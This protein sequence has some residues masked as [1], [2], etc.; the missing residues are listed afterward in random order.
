VSREKIR[1]SSTRRSQSL[2]GTMPEP[3]PPD[4]TSVPEDDPWASPAAAAPK[5]R[6]E[7]CI[8]PPKSAAGR[9]F[10]YLYLLRFSLLLWL[11]LPAFVVLDWKNVLTTATR[12]ILT[13]ES[14][15]GWIWAGFFV[16][17]TGWIALLSARITCAYGEERFNLEPPNWMKVGTNMTWRTFLL[18]QAPGLVMLGYLWRLSVT[19]GERTGAAAALS[20]LSLLGGALIALAL[21]ALLTAFSYWSYQTDETLVKQ[22]RMTKVR[23]KPTGPDGLANTAFFAPVVTPAL[24]KALENAPSPALSRGFNDLFQRLGRGAGPGFHK[25][26]CD[27]D[28]PLNSGHMIALILFFYLAFLYY[29]FSFY[30]AP[31]PLDGMRFWL[32]VPVFGGLV[33]WF[34]KALPY[35]K[36]VAAQ[37]PRRVA[38]YLLGVAVVLLPVWLL[39]GYSIAL[40]WRQKPNTHFPV[41]ASIYILLF[42][43]TSGL[44][45]LAFL[46]DRYRVPVLTSAILAL[47]PIH[48]VA[49]M[50]GLRD[51]P[52]GEAQHIVQ[53][54]SPRGGAPASLMYPKEVLQRYRDTHPGN[55]PIVIVT[56]T[57]GGIHAAA[58][59]A[60]LLGELEKEF[61][62][63]NTAIPFHDSILLL[64]T[65]SGGSVGASEWIQA[66]PHYN[67]EGET[68]T[69]SG[70]ANFTETSGTPAQT[71]AQR[72]TECSSLEAIAWGLIYP[73]IVHVF[74][75]FRISD[76]IEGLDR[77]WALQRA[78]ERNE[79]AGCVSRED[80]GK[81]GAPVKPVDVFG[82][83]LGDFARTLGSGPA[84]VPA[85]SLN[86]TVA[87]TGDRF[88]LADYRLPVPTTKHSELLPASSFLDVFDHADTPAP[89]LA[90]LPLSAA[91]RLSA[92]FPFVSSMARVPRNVAQTPYHF[93]DGGYFDNDGTGTV[94]EFLRE[95]YLPKPED[96]SADE[97]GPFD[98]SQTTSGTPPPHAGSGS[99]PSV[100]D[101]IL[102]IEI[103]D[104]DDPLS[105]NPPDSLSNQ[106][107]PH[108]VWGP[109]EQLG[110][111]VQT[112]YHAGHESV[113][114]RNR[115]ELCVLESALAGTAQRISIEHYVFA[116]S[117][118]RK[119]VDQPLNWH[120]TSKD[121]DEIRQNIL[122]ESTV[123]LEERIAKRFKGTDP[124]PGF[125]E[126]ADSQ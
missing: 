73:D 75:P 83:T 25:D 49:G 92:S 22:H 77:S 63:Q 111:P 80:A 21:W 38:M 96:R 102:L 64:S 3:M 95:A 97:S 101:R 9:F 5:P 125:C 33:L 8:A 19:D 106:K 114:R 105:D 13:I 50:K 44:A 117:N 109:A 85:F 113:T 120:L 76:G 122:A 71:A 88:L 27:P 37:G 16:T 7:D 53:T 42:A 98:K 4:A 41:I 54:L 123:K 118:K 99:P 70:F 36:S 15:W 121:K 29:V 66:Y 60:Q 10:G 126:I 40:A 62:L 89:Q 43:L 90:D 69:S 107:A 79:P 56:A 124:A 11:S 81:A 17:L 61:A 72:I 39:V 45:G 74:I 78:I 86:T 47:I 82:A 2:E 59:T 52:F 28:S 31:V 6:N 18:A 87:E 58:W 100:S 46:L 84:W 115:R 108:A 65:V 48:L 110:G 24:L 116:Y 1:R 34:W 14:G 57:G 23:S 68:T 26:P 55:S 35:L 67:S 20:L 91:A 12:G 119:N 30:T 103:R 51:S 94:I 32:L 104:G 112:F 93:G